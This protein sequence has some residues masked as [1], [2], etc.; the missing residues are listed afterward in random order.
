MMTDYAKELDHTT[1]V[2]LLATRVGNVNVSL[3]YR[4]IGF[5][6]AYNITTLTRMP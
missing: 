3:F 6:L 4:K 2:S 5:F 1:P